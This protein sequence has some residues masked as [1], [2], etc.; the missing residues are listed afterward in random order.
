MDRSDS[1]TATHPHSCETTSF[2]HY[3]ESHTS[4]LLLPRCPSPYT[5]C[6]CLIYRSCYDAHQYTAL[7]DATTT[8]AVPAAHHD[9][10]ASPV[11]EFP[12]VPRTPLF[13]NR[14]ANQENQSA[15]CFHLCRKLERSRMP[16]SRER[17]SCLAMCRENGDK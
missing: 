7:R 16:S 10:P 4:W 12:R 11:L 13:T 5:V 1:P 14:R 2:A 6:V 15:L 8:T 9:R 3:E 17:H